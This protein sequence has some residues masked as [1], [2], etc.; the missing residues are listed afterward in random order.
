MIDRG[1][2]RG[3]SAQRLLTDLASLVRYALDQ[4]EELAPFREHVQARF[5]HWLAQQRTAGRA[6]TP[7]QVRWLEMIRDH[8]A[9]SVEMTLDDLDYAPFAEEGG[10]GRAAQVFG[11][12]LRPLLEEL[13]EVL[14]A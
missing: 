7:L 13:N 1:V 5:D 14:A 2:V 8:V 3:A 6:F 11:S 9:A 12:E 4:D 10:L